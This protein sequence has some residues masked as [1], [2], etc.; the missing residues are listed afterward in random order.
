MSINEEYKRIIKEY[1]QLQRFSGI[2]DA[3][4]VAQEA[5][6]Q[7]TSYS[8]ALHKAALDAARPF[9][10]LIAQANKANNAHLAVMQAMGLS[11]AR[12]ISSA[13]EAAKRAAGF[14]SAI[15]QAQELIKKYHL[16][17]E[18]YERFCV[19]N[20]IQMAAAEI[21]RISEQFDLR[22]YP[23]SV[24][25]GAAA[26]S[27]LLEHAYDEIE[28][29]GEISTFE[30]F[31]DDLPRRSNSKLNHFVFW[32]FFIQ[33]L[34]DVIAKIDDFMSSAAGI[35]KPNQEYVELHQSAKALFNFGIIN[36]QQ[37]V[38]SATQ[39]THVSIATTHVQL[40]SG[41]S[42][43]SE[44]LLVL[45]PST[46]FLATG[47]SDDWVSGFATLSDGTTKPGWIHSDYLVALPEDND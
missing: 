12:S 34:L 15:N 14:S 3:A 2:T 38:N 7:T 37:S 19:P 45:P 42:T 31:G 24:S 9:S 20:A 10:D 47:K 43:T 16:E 28:S 22:D 23:S 4:K 30:E 21:K 25:G 29:R 6:K 5:V 18:L 40:R 39:S 46:Q 1:Q 11:E 13:I 44:R 36:L 33:A 26:Y 8:D 32:L 35:E 27:L 17:Q 41:P